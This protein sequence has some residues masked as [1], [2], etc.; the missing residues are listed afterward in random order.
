M[1][2]GEQLERREDKMNW[3]AEDRLRIIKALAILGPQSETGKMLLERI[4]FLCDMPSDFLEA[5][6]DQFREAI[7]LAE[8]DIAISL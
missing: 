2:Q 8:A 4:M 6:R 1:G 7:K 3:T 5:N